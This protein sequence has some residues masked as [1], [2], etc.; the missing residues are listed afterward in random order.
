MFSMVF[1]LKHRSKWKVQKDNSYFVKHT[2][3]ET[4][5]NYLRRIGLFKEEK[6]KNMSDKQLNEFVEA[7]LRVKGFD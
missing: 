2:D 5:E 7:G 6:I 4:K 3:R 1:K